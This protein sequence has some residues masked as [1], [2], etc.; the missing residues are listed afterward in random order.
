MDIADISIGQ[1]LVYLS[2]WPK[3]RP[4]PRIRITETTLGHVV[5]VV[6]DAMGNVWEEGSEF[7]C[8]PRHLH[9]PGDVPPVQVYRGGPDSPYGKK[10]R[11]P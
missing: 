5:G 2:F 4:G 11:L 7:L 9:L 6:V 1:E 8:L 3:S 10:R